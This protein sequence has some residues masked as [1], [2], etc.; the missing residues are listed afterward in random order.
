MELRNLRNKAAYTRKKFEGEK[1]KLIEL[2]ARK[3]EIKAKESAARHKETNMIESAKEKY[4][5]DF[6]DVE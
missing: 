6:E 4:G 5:I 1:E 3:K 2:N